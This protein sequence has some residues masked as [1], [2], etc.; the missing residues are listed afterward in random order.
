MKERQKKK[1]KKKVKNLHLNSLITY[2]VFC[3][4]SYISRKN[5]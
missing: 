2:F 3:N 4:T 1:K 5:K